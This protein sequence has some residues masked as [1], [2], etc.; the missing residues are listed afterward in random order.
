MAGRG[1]VLGGLAGHVVFRLAGGQPLLRSF[2]IWGTIPAMAFLI[3]AESRDR[4]AWAEM[5]WVSRYVWNAGAGAIIAASLSGYVLFANAWIGG[6]VPVEIRGRVVANQHQGGGARSSH[7]G[8][9]IETETGQRL[10]LEAS[11]TVVERYPVGSEYSA[12]WIRGSL[13]ILYRRGGPGATFE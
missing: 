2:V 11:R 13:G 7:S 8:L 1:A 3:W 4:A 10:W 9:R 6:R 12:T 5:G